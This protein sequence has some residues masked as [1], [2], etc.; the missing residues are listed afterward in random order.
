MG[1]T[2][3]TRHGRADLVRCHRLGPQ[4]DRALQG[5]SRDPTGGPMRGVRHR[6]RS[7]RRPV[8]PGRG[9]AEPA[10]PGPPPP[11]TPPL[12]PGTPS[13]RSSRSTSRPASG[14]VLLD[15]SDADNEWQGRCGGTWTPST[16]PSGGPAGEQ[17]CYVYSEASWSAGQTGHD[18]DRGGQRVPGRH[19]H[20][21]DSLRPPHV[22]RSDGHAAGAHRRRCRPRPHM[23]QGG[24]SGQRMAHVPGHRRVRLQDPRHLRT[25]GRSIGY[26]HR[27]LR[28][29]VLRDRQRR[30]R[31]AAPL[32]AGSARGAA[33]RHAGAG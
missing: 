6:I 13:R 18:G 12:P 32:R 5:A 16:G 28:G 15:D 1:N 8:P 20:F 33:S 30:R 3:A 7:R 2:G 22:R 24:R 27:R 11:P 19:R 21:D 14:A 17:D 9:P 31:R 26:G 23:E 10:A 4:P 25:G 29:G